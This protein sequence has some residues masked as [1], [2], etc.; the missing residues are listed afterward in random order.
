MK[1]QPDSKTF[2]Y[3]GI[4]FF[5]VAAASTAA[6][7]IRYAQAFTDS[8][9]IAA[10][11]MGIATLILLPIILL[12]H[13]QELKTITRNDLLKGLLAGAFLAAHF[14]TWITSLEMTSVAVSVLMVTTT[15]IWVALFSPLFLKETLE[16]KAVFG[17]VVAV[18]GMTV[19]VLGESC[20]WQS[21][22]FSCQF[23]AADNSDSIVLGNILA[24]IGALCAAGYLMVG[25][26]VRKKVS[27]MPYTFMVYG[28]AALILFLLLGFRGQMLSSPPPPEAFL[29]LL[30]L[31]VI[32]QLLG[33][34]SL[35]YV[36]Q[37]L[38]ATMISTMLLTE[39]LMS[40]WMAYILFGER[41]G[42]KTLIGAI[43]I[44]SGIGFIISGPLEDVEPKGK[45]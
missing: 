19:V 37:Y 9:T 27:L 36:I 44:L 30:L 31:A 25:R 22:G 12:K 40:G 10:Y 38:P 8:L 5:G 1:K 32:P 23:A 6:I 4:A 34:S 28:T 15:P 11:R 18:V 29:W 26:S 33:H 17:L 41:P 3:L 13:N 2:L 16:K 45:E 7:F 14:A 21:R 35:N 24:W 42:L 20:S 43:L 39:P